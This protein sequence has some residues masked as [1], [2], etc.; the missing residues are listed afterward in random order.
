MPKESIQTIPESGIEADLKDMKFKAEGPIVYLI[1]ALVFIWAI[2]T[3]KHK[4]AGALIKKTGKSI[5][6]RLT[7]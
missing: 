6:K 1:A 3:G 7:P 5:K 2:K 4:K